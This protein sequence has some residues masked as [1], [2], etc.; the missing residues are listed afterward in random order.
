MVHISSEIAALNSVI[1]HCPGDEHRFVSPHNIVEWIPENGTLVHNPDYLL[2]DDLIQPERAANEHH[3]LTNVLS[4]F[5]GNDNTIQFTDLLHEILDDEDTR[6]SLIDE[7]CLLE[8]E[9]YDHEISIA[10]KSELYDM[11]SDNL[12]HVLLSGADTR[13]D[14][15]T[16][17]KYPVPNLI[18]TRD[19][20]A[21]VGNTILLTWGRR[22][23]RKRENILAKFETENPESKDNPDLNVRAI[24]A[25]T[26]KIL[27]L[28]ECNNYHAPFDNYE[29]NTSHRTIFL[30]QD[31]M[32]NTGHYPDGT[33]HQQLFQCNRSN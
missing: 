8:A 33:T 6:K 1:V 20:A 12:I 15:M 22:R 7:C 31:I 26:N 29:S 25:R 5:I 14:Y 11:S 21:V 9:S 27:S 4:Y 30:K 17:F 2:F 23:V 10:N 18:F 32:L 19:I 16:Y 24:M 3:Q 28:K 13:N